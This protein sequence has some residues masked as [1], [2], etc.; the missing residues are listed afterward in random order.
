M[1]HLASLLR[2]GAGALG[3]AMAFGALAACIHAEGAPGA[4]LETEAEPDLDPQGLELSGPPGCLQQAQQN[5]AF[6][7]LHNGWLGGTE[8][9]AGPLISAAQAC[10]CVAEMIITEARPN[11][12][13]IPRVAASC[14]G[15]PPFT[16]VSWFFPGDY[17]CTDA[18]GNQV[19]VPMPTPAEPFMGIHVNPTT[20]GPLCDVYLNPTGP[21]YR[22]A[23]HNCSDCHF[24]NKPKWSPTPA[25]EATGLE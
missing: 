2:G 19:L 5:P 9:G 25:G 12:E 21:T 8:G 24:Q 23:G 7:C 22:E 13:D 16:A 3:L 1:S 17:L 11:C 15:S 4:D 20:N 10:G 14:P 18:Q 6:E